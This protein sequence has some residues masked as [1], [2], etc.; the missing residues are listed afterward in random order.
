MAKRILKIHLKT[1]EIKTVKV[2]S[3]E[4]LRAVLIA[5][6]ASPYT[7]IT[8]IF[9]CG[10]RGLCATCGVYIYNTIEATHWHDKLAH[11]FHYPRLSCQISVDCDME[12]EIPNKLIWGNRRKI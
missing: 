1:G 9:N 8:K 3:G 6:G 5:S 10:G 7:Q 4:N 11:Q 12:I 2:D